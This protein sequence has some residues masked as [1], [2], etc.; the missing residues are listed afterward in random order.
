[1][2][3][4]V[5]TLHED[6]ASRMSGGSAGRGKQL[7]VFL[8]VLLI[9][10]VSM[11]AAEFLDLLDE[12]LCK[13]VA[14]HG[15][16]PENEFRGEKPCNIPPFGGVQLICCGDYFQL[17]PI[18][19][20]VPMETWSRL[21]ER[22][23]R[24]HRAVLCTGLD[25]REQELFLNRGFAFQS[26]SWWRA[27]LVFIELTRV[28]RQKDAQLVATLNRVRKGAMSADDCRYLNRHCATVAKR[29]SV[30]G[31]AVA[32][33][34]AAFSLAAQPAPRPM[35]LAPVNAVVNERNARELQEVMRRNSLLGRRVHQWMA[36]DWVSVDDESGGVFEEVHARLMRSESGSFFGDCLAERRVDLC[37]GARVILL[38]NLDLDA[39][40]DQKL[41]N[42]S[43]GAIGPMPTAEEVR[44]A[45][46]AKLAELDQQVE[47]LREQVPAAT[48]SEASRESL[49]S[50]I[51]YYDLY[52]VRLQ[53]W[54]A[55]DP[56]AEGGSGGE[57]LRA[58]GCW[59]RP[60]TLPRVHFD[61]GREVIILPVLLQSEVVGQGI[62]YRLQLPLRPAWAITI[63]K[64]QGMTL[65]SGAR[66]VLTLCTRTHA[67]LSQ[68]ACVELAHAIVHV[69]RWPLVLLS[70]PVRVQLWC[71]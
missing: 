17:P 65:D 12:Q 16:G 59:R 71:K 70:G 40:A 41:C 21:S 14:R 60:Y 61:N 43:L 18:T 19:G 58:G 54:V 32:A 8:K 31:A 20:R 11:L 53:R 15:R 27:S 49:M 13:L 7:A 9:D 30:G 38:Y 22:A 28:W 24:E 42:G 23:L 63:H 62:C 55:N 45:L 46:E 64:S 29:P 56:A 34:A 26:V 2:G 57:A 33:P 37:E 39:D 10:E 44:Q 5:P 52:R 35:L 36:S 25:Q 4:G 68:V 48:D 1:M 67:R 69:N 50:R 6:F 66:H 3:V 51:A 47:V